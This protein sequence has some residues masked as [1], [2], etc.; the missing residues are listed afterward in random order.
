MALGK[1][2]YEPFRVSAL[3]S[4][5]GSML[6]IAG[7]LPAIAEDASTFYKGRSLTIGVPNAAGGGYDTYVRALAQYLSRHI[8]G[9]PAIIVQDIPAAGGM[10]MAN[11]LYVTAPKDGT[12]IGMVRGTVLEEELFKNSQV[13]FDDRKFNW[14][15]NMNSDVDG[16]VVSPASGIKTIS[17]FY[18]KQA[19]AAATGVGAQSYSFP[20]A[21]QKILGMK[22]KVIS[23]YRGTPDR[24]MAME[25]G[26]VNSAC[27]ITVSTFRS[28]VAGF[29]RAGK[30]FLVAQAG[31]HKDPRYPDLPNMLDE[32][33][34]PEA[35]QMMR[36]LFTPLAL[37]RPI[38]APPRT[39]AD[40][41]ALLRKAMTDT[42]ADPDFQALAEKVQIDIQPMTGEETARAVDSMF[43]I[44]P[45]TA[46]QLKFI[47]GE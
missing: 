39:S 31:L 44:S 26:E 38:A 42:L 37:G 15:V 33:K 19:V 10:V 43:T 47:I 32:A 18:V 27:G 34:T 12:Y 25:R 28:Q 29:A 6:L 16:C 40:R 1:L 20:I 8:P 45:A 21:Y 3:A 30:V 36:V 17:D 11:Q 35:K 7:I 5:V 46:A 9:R 4:A 2:M 23:G 13:E 14:L 22:F 24:I 41:V